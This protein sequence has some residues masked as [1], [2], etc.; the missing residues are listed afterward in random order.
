MKERLYKT[1]FYASIA[2]CLA[3]MFSAMSIS[4]AEFKDGVTHLSQKEFME[5]VKEP[6][7][8]V[9]DVRTVREYRRGFIEG[10]INHPH[11]TILKDVTILDQY[12]GKDLIFYCHSGVRAKILTDYVRETKKVK[13]ARLFHLK[14]DTRAW[15]ARGLPLVKPN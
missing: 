4:A 13:D 7:V 5:K 9:I 6:N 3:L 12:V 8:V 2:L 11:K 14:G 1:P 15:R 10:A